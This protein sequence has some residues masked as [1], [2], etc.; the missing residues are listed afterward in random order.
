MGYFR[1]T[2]RKKMEV[3]EFVKMLL[4]GA[5][6]AVI[7]VAVSLLGSLYMGYLVHAYMVPKC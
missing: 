3:F 7:T 6:F 5:V 2:E 4:L 1:T